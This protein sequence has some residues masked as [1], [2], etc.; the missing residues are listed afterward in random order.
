[1]NREER[2]IS[3]FRVIGTIQTVG[4]IENIR[5]SWERLQNHPNSDIDA[6]LSVVKIRNNVLRPH[7]LYIK[8]NNTVDAILACRLEKIAV[9]VK[10]G[11][12]KIA[13]PVIN[14]LT[15]IYS[16]LMGDSSGNSCQYLLS[17]LIDLIQKGEAD[18]IY[19]NSLPIK[20]GLYEAIEN[21]SYPMRRDRMGTNNQHWKMTLPDSI[22]TFLKRMSQKHRY[23]L[24]R[25]P[26]VLEKEYVGKV[27]YR[28]YHDIKDV[29][30]L[31]RDAEDIAK[32]TY[33]RGLNVGFRHDNEMVDR[34]TK[35]AMRGRLRSYFLYVDNMPCAFWIGTLYKQV[36]HLD[37]TSYD[38]IYHKYEP[39]TIL[40]IRM[41]EDLCKNQIREIDFGFGDAF[42]KTRFGDRSWEESSFYI[43]SRSIDGMKLYILRSVT[44]AISNKAKAI[45]KNTELLTKLK[46]RWRQSLESKNES[47]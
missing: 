35:H 45:I 18:A 4:E 6:Y 15:V 30:I 14:Q 34:L 31:C 25:L 20:S 27:E 5:E 47:N 42:Y 7:I 26:R 21:T 43:Y 12:K 33:Q 46:K 40:F 22:E 37:Y 17:G 23:W 39:G 8:N 19:F 16:G 1:M 28:Y 13:S 9:P 11:Y 10:I 29:P 44:N 38:P 3:Q 24:R 32:K 2:K 36:F 41:V